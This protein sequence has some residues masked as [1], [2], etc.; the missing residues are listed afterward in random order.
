MNSNTS[1]NRQA[2]GAGGG[3]PAGTEALAAAVG[4]LAAQDLD[5]LSDAVRAERVLVLRGLVDRLEGCWL[6]ELA[7]VDARGVAGA[8]R[9]V[10][11]GSTAGWLRR[12][13]RLGAS[14][15]S[16]C[17][18]T[19]RACFHGPL[20]QTGQALAAGE[21]SP[22]HASVLAHST[23]DLP[24]HVTGEVEPVLVEAARRLDPPRLRR[25]IGHL[26]QVRPRR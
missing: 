14:A 6:R 17:V 1:S 7:A 11:E 4:G 5:G 13:L 12:R 25:A 3:L 23:H 15:A 24:P 16:S 9:G 20:I 19:A 21:L 2:A 26:R 18:R 10:Q 8:E 22:S